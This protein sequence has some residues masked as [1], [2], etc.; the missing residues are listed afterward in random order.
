M[1]QRDIA[2]RP[3]VRAIAELPPEPRAI[4]IKR[5]QPGSNELG[6]A[7]EQALDGLRRDGTLGQLSKARF[8]AD[9]SE[10]P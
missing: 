9:L 4:V 7:I 6:A 3:D 10:V 5:D 1:S 2:A 8:G